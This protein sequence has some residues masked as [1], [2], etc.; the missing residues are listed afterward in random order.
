MLV[1]IPYTKFSRFLHP[2]F[3]V[4]RHF[5]ALFPKSETNTCHNLPRYHLLPSWTFHTFPNTFPDTSPNIP[6]KHPKMPR[7][8]HSDGFLY[9]R[10]TFP[11]YFSIKALRTLY[12]SVGI[13][14]TLFPHIKTD[15]PRIPS[16]IFCSKW[17]LESVL[18]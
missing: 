12:L 10:W 4:K 5:L 15:F 1:W 13:S 8:W 14:K 17:Y 6:H 3:Y 11:L 9:L 16:K 7:K 2:G 18:R